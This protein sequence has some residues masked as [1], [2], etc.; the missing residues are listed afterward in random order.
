MPGNPIKLSRMAEGPLRR[1]PGPGEHTEQVLSG[2]LD[3][4]TD[5]IERLREQGAF[6]S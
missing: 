5:E 4:D 3:L 2:L 6:G 1:Y